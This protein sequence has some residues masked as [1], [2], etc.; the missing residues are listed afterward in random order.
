MT[1][2]VEIR[3]ED[4]VEGLDKLKMDKWKDLVSEMN[5]VAFHRVTPDKEVMVP[6]KDM[7]R[8]TVCV[9]IAKKSNVLYL[10]FRGMNAYKAAT[11]IG[12]K[13]AE[14]VD[15]TCKSQRW[16][17]K[18]EYDYMWKHQITFEE[19]EAH[20]EEVYKIK[21]M[22]NPKKENPPRHTHPV[23]GAGRYLEM[24]PELGEKE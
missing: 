1:S 24:G 16:I 17:P 3:G 4:E 2:I 7:Y 21:Q 14:L 18:Q 5:K 13:I 23:P 15:G 10:G 9:F 11:H 12:N 8:N 19:M 22:K 20:N 6:V